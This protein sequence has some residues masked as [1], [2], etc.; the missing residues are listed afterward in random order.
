MLCDLKMY[1]TWRSV[2]KL[3]PA[4][5]SNAAVERLFLRR[6]NI[7]R[8]KRATLSD[9]NYEKQMFM[10]GNTITSRQ[11]RKSRWRSRNEWISY[12]IRIIRR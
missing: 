2:L 8:A 4:I 11:L 3:N 9:A 1:I 7:L 5:P 10:K 6:R 12:A